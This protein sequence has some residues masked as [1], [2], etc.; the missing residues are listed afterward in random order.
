MGVLFSVLGPVHAAADEPTVVASAA[1][2]GEA[3]D[4]DY[5]ATE[6]GYW[7]TFDDG[8]VETHGDAGFFGERPGLRNDESVSALSRTPS[9]R[10]YWLFT[11][12]GRVHAYGDARHF[13]DLSTVRSPDGRPI[14][15][16]LNGPIIGSIATP[17]GAGYWMVAS[18]GGIF[19]FGDAEFYGSMGGEPLN[20]P[21]VGLAPTPSNQGY[22]LVATDGGIFAFGDAE[23]Y[24][25]VPG[26][27]APGQSLNASVTSMLPQ[28][29]G[30]MMVASD[31]GIFNFGESQFWGSLGG[32]ALPAP[33]VTATVLSD[34]S[35]YLMIDTIGTVHGFGNASVISAGPLD[36]IVDE[37]VRALRAAD[38][39]TV[40]ALFAND[41]DAQQIYSEYAGRNVFKPS[42]C[43]PTEEYQCNIAADRDAVT[44]LLRID[45]IAGQLLISDI[46]FFHTT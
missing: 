25:S 30:Y 35:G 1:A 6:A 5:S 23:F 45:R 3:V 38:V 33:I 31:G 17:T 34:R 40:S 16:V 19:A 24:G 39:S 36:D 7:V 27:L 43:F 21:V 28:G 9:G 26:E 18:D 32:Q 44:Y 22:W 20:G 41:T 29:D 14:A 15:E 42:N 13:G 37:L 8:R 10:G 4:V 12:Q 11:D 2:V 46:Q